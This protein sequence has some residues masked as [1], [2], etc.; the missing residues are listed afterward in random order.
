[1]KSNPRPELL[2]SPIYL[3]DTGEMVSHPEKW[4]YQIRWMAGLFWQ[5]I[6]EVDKSSESLDIAYNEGWDDGASELGVENEN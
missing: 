2:G 3:P 1:M 4:N 5:L 6:D